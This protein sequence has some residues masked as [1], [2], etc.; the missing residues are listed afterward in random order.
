MQP[1][2]HAGTDTTAATVLSMTSPLVLTQQRQLLLQL[3]PV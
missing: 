3:Q 2:L 1:V